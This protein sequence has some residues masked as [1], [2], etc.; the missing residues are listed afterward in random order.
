MF[1][2]GSSN[3]KLGRATTTVTGT[4]HVLHSTASH[5]SA[6]TGCSRQVPV[7]LERNATHEQQSALQTV[8]LCSQSSHCIGRV[9]HQSNCHFR[10]F[11][12]QPNSFSS[13]FNMLLA[14][15]E[16]PQLLPPQ[17]H[18]LALSI[19]LNFSPTNRPFRVEIISNGLS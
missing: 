14:A 13:S 16:T 4:S 1:E 8:S 7:Q 5:C 12:P 18:T 2:L 19:T 6:L 17:L 11:L 10:P 3:L 15:K 9:K